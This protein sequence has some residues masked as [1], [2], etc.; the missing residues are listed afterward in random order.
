MDTSGR[1]VE[2]LSSK[3]QVK[4]GHGKESEMSETKKKGA[5]GAIKA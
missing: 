1:T 2:M 3:G 5:Q 4:M